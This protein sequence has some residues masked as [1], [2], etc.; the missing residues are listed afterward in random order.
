VL[1]TGPQSKSREETQKSNQKKKKKPAHGWKNRISIDLTSITST[2]PKVLQVYIYYNTGLRYNLTTI[3]YKQII[4]FS[5]NADE[6]QDKCSLHCIQRF[7]FQLLS[8]G[9]Q[10]PTHT[11]FYPFISRQNYFSCAER[12]VSCNS[13]RALPSALASSS[14]TALR[15]LIKALLVSCSAS[16]S[17]FF[18]FKK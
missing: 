17:T 9:V 16:S 8:K 10:L 5:A 11:S 7:L 13:R 18:N 14:D 15:A 4:F 3:A 1:T 12:P 2:H 6:Y